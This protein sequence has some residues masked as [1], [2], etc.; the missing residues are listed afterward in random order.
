[1]IPGVALTRLAPK[2]DAASYQTYGVT[3]PARTHWKAATCAQVNCPRREQGWKQT[4]D[5]TTELGQKQARYIKLHSGRSYVK[6]SQADGIVVLVFGAGQDCFDEHRIPLD[7][8]SLFTLRGGDWRGNPRGI[9]LRRL[10]PIAWRDDF[11]EHQE[12]L[13]D[14]AKRG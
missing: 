5:L 2:M 1:M 8:D 13:A 14:L 7:R 10:S 12:K 6:E 3:R 4:I 9:P 11:G